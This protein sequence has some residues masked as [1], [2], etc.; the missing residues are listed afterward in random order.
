MNKATWIAISLALAGGCSNASNVAIEPHTVGA[1]RFDVPENVSVNPTEDSL[2]LYMRPSDFA[3]LNRDTR[4][5]RLFVQIQDGRKPNIAVAIAGLKRH[6]GVLGDELPG[7][8]TP[9]SGGGGDGHYFILNRYGGA[10]IFCPVNGLECR[11]R[12]PYRDLSVSI[13]FSQALLP[14]WA[15]IIDGVLSKVETMEA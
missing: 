5:E 15:R 13:R 1:H 4:S 8:L 3:L 12:V 7:G 14:D 6:G 10:S 2:A 11:A 9:V